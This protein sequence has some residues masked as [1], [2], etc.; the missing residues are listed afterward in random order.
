MSADHKHCQDLP[1]VAQALRRAR[2]AGQW[3]AHPTLSWPQ[4]QTA[5]RYRQT[6]GMLGCLCP[7]N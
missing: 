7:S 4:R 5:R 6:G 2:E 1:A 3:P